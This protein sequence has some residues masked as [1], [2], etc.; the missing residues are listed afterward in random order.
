M[1][2]KLAPLSFPPPSPHLLKLSF[3]GGKKIVSHLKHLFRN[4]VLDETKI[5]NL[6][7]CG[8]MDRFFHGSLHN[9]PSNKCKTDPND[10]K[11]PPKILDWKQSG[12]EPHS[13]KCTRLKIKRCEFSLAIFVFYSSKN[14]FLS[15][16]PSKMHLC[17][18]AISTRQNCIYSMSLSFENSTVGK[19]TFKKDLRIRVITQKGF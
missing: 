3:W 10:H 16:S 11:S 14:S 2:F 18:Q 12:N 13:N 1:T 7:R 15:I 5:F 9:E 19:I 8:D 4:D 6:P 17:F